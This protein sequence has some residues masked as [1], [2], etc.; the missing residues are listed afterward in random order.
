MEQTRP[1][2]TSQPPR[3][4]ALAQA[5]AAP[6]RLHALTKLLADVDEVQAVAPSRKADFAHQNRLVQV[7]LG[8]AT[9]LFHA[10][11]EAT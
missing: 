7:R 9:S 6:E 11:E 10:L 2:S 8:I 5:E 1:P 4:L 3:S